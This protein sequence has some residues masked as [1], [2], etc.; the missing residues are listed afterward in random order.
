MKKTLIISVFFMALV[1]GLLFY[2]KN[3]SDDGLFKVMSVPDFELID[4]NGEKITNKDMLGKVYVVEFFFTNCPTICPIMNENLKKVEK[5]INSPDF[6]VVSIT[7]DPKRDTPEVLKEHKK[8]LR[9]DNPNWHM[10]TEDKDY[11]VSLSKR[12]NIY[13]E[14]DIGSAT[15]LDHSG[16]VALIDKKG[17]IRSRRRP[18]GVPL[19]YYSAVNYSDENGKKADLKGQYHPQIE[20]LKEDIKLLLEE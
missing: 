2:W 14:E 3:S 4:E 12:F 1:F 16:N 20:Y 10:A 5:E 17:R 7:I 6:G 15:G 18:S 9:I 13:V 19:M 11:I 8:R